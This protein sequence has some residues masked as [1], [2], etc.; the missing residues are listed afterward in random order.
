MAKHNTDQ[1]SH[2]IKHFIVVI[3]FMFYIQSIE[4]YIVLLFTHSDGMHPKNVLM[5]V[6]EAKINFRL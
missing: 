5:A 6:K 1:H 3:V 2:I 4:K